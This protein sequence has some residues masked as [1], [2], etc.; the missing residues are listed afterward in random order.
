[1]PVPIMSGDNTL[2]GKIE[3]SDEVLDILA[4]AFLRGTE[5][6]FSPVILRSDNSVKIMAFNLLPIPVRPLEVPYPLTAEEKE[7]TIELFK[8]ANPNIGEIIT[9]DPIKFFP[10]TER[11]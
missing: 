7:R 3:I 2:L 5:F 4:K 9:D 6:T 8:K 10:N 1:M 11:S